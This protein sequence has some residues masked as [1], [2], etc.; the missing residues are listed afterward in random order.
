VSDHL[1]ALATNAHALVLLFPP[2][3]DSV[4]RRM[5]DN[6]AATILMAIIIDGLVAP[7]LLLQAVS[8]DWVGPGSG[9]SLLLLVLLPLPSCRFCRYSFRRRMLASK[10]RRVSTSI[11]SLVYFRSRVARGTTRQIW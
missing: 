1:Q 8:S 11:Q 3:H 7:A 2:I 9:K 4:I 6:Y 5:S 10:E